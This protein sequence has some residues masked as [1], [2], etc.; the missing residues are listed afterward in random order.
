MDHSQGAAPGQTVGAA[1][2]ANAQALSWKNP[3]VC[4]G[5]RG[6]LWAGGRG[7]GERWGDSWAGLGAGFL[8]HR[9]A[10]VMPGVLPAAGRGSAGFPGAFRDDSWGFHPVP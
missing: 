10:A 6:V 7:S 5:L 1:G 4:W 3:E 2:T 8:A 9:G